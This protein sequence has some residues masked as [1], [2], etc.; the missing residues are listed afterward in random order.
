MN[1][2][3][4]HH[5]VIKCSI[6]LIHLPI[7][8]Y[9]Y[10]LAM[11]KYQWRCLVYPL[12]VLLKYIYLYILIHFALV[13]IVLRTHSFLILMLFLLLYCRRYSIKLVLQNSQQRTNGLPLSLSSLLLQFLLFIH[14]MIILLL[15]IHR[16]SIL[17]FTSSQ[18]GKY[19]GDH[20]LYLIISLSSLSLDCISIQISIVD[21]DR[22]FLLPRFV[23]PTLFLSL[24][25][26]QI[27]PFPS[28][29]V[30][31]ISIYLLHYSQI[32]SSS[33]FFLFYSVLF[34][35][36]L[37]YSILFYSI[38]FYSILFYSP[39]ISSPSLLSLFSPSDFSKHPQGGASFKAE[40]KRVDS[41]T[42]LFIPRECEIRFV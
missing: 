30:S 36:I 14:S 27:T 33:I 41:D 21:K 19:T 4:N 26:L 6:D 42:P 24:L 20:S 16:P 35:S 40:I 12:R 7:Y 13:T 34:Y 3:Q 29:S 18:G 17:C 38:L 5:R 25:R 9:I 23:S 39:S 32:S 15:F 11:D 22:S 2:N 8:I 28:I 10:C 31:I 1:H 37:F